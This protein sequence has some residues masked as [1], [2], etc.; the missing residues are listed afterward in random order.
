MNGV[1]Q[2]STAIYRACSSLKP[3][4]ASSTSALIGTHGTRAALAIQS[5]KI[6]RRKGPSTDRL[7]EGW[8]QEQGRAVGGFVS[9]LTL[10]EGPLLAIGAS[11]SEAVSTSL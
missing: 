7:E 1:K 6:D 3:G 5:I 4:W 8:P 11:Q 9:L 10:K 2:L